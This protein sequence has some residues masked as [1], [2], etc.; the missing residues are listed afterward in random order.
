MDKAELYRD[1]KAEID[2]VV[3]GETS[4][5]A[6]Y[7]TAACILAQAFKPRFFWTGFYVV[8]PL[9]ERELVVG[10]Y[11]GTLGCLR[12]PFGKGVCGHVAATQEPIIVPDVH[13]FP[14]HIACDSATNS[15]IVVPVFDGE[16]RLAA[17]LDIDSTEH[18]AFDEIDRDGL[19][20]VCQG[21]LT[22]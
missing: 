4:I 19:V 12:I 13:A 20:A 18:D 15:E 1:L 17:V 11:Q 6:R 22:A 7:A 10:P 5:T 16:G 21:L 2:A 3:A 14:G 9:K 8:D